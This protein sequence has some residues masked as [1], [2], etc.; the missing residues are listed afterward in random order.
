MNLR[1]YAQQEV[2]ASWEQQAKRQGFAYDVYVQRIKATQ[3]VKLLGGLA[4][5]LTSF[6]GFG[7]VP[8]TGFQRKTLAGLAAQ[9]LTAMGHKTSY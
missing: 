6:K 4:R 5:G 3:D 2:S 7:G 1:K 9:R 8:L